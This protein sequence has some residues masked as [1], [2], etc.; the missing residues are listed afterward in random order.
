MRCEDCGE[1]RNVKTTTSKEHYEKLYPRCTK[2]ARDKNRL[3]DIEA[4][5]KRVHGAY[6]SKAQKA[7][8]EFDIRLDEFSAYIEGPCVYCGSVGGNA[9]DLFGEGTDKYYYNGVDRIDNDKGYITGNCQSC[10]K[11]CNIAKRD[12]THEE[13]LEWIRRAHEYNR[14]IYEKDN[15]I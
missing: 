11:H 15:S 7:G 10:C 5:R 12:R 3:T 13:F 4:G 14:R 9:L 1:M 8:R 6:K 2:C